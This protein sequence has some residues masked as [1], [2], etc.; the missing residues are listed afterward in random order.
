MKQPA[1]L[2]IAFQPI[3]SATK[4]G[5]ARYGY[6]ALARTSRGAVPALLMKG[7]PSSELYAL[8]YHCRE[9]ALREAVR[10]GLK[11]N[12]SLNVTPG[13]VCHPEYGV[14]ATIE[15]AIDIGFDIT[16]LVF[17]ITEREL[18]ADYAPLRRC[19][20]KHRS[21]G[22]RI[23]LDDFGTGSNNLNTLLDLRPDIVKVDMK[24]VQ[25]IESDY[26]R[27]ALM[28]GICSGGDKLGMRLIAEGVETLA[29]VCALSTMNIDLMQGYFFSRPSVEQLS[30]VADDTVAQVVSTLSQMP[31]SAT[32]GDMTGAQ[33]L[34]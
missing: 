1:V 4:Y 28:F 12:L 24:F 10:L 16:K 22:V 6:E 7:L 9:S 32:V 21:D 8:D 17:E 19:L 34:A 5:V 31:G 33:P 23:A 14:D 26:D 25:K 11:E 30:F 3:V 20:D 13:V 15:S 2:R 27:Q 29:G 18:I